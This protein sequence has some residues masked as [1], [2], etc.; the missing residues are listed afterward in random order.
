[1][2]S[3]KTTSLAVA[4][5]GTLALLVTVGLPGP[6]WL[7]VALAAAAVIELAALVLTAGDRHA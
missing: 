3:K 7:A 1:M 2:P 6:T 5:T 4:L